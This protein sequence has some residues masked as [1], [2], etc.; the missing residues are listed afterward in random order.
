MA[1]N[2]LPYKF[3]IFAALLYQ[4]LFLSAC[5][6]SEMV[7]T[8][9]NDKKTYLALLEKNPWWQP[10]S[11]GCD[12]PPYSDWHPCF[13][14]KVMYNEIL[15]QK[16]APL[17]H[18][19]ESKLSMQSVLASHP[20]ACDTEPLEGYAEAVLKYHTPRIEAMRA[21]QGIQLPEL[22]KEQLAVCELNQEQYS[23]SPPIVYEVQYRTCVW[24]LQ[25]G[26]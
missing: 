4:M 1:A 21:K 20:Y 19:D 3:L 13:V 10:G 5:R 23:D 17:C 22:S 18:S 9:W 26:H 24:K 15:R 25:G 8:E 2:S 12:T 6:D 14:P 16:M 7:K 11:L